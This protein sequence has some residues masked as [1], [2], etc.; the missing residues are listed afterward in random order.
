MTITR[1][2][3]P[4]S[5]H[6]GRRG[7][8]ARRRFRRGPEEGAVTAET[9]LVLPAVVLVLAAAVWVVSLA[10]AT[11]RCVDAAREAARALARGET[12]ALAR[13]LAEQV[14]PAGA[15]MRTSSD[16]G[17]VRVTVSVRARPPGPVLGRLPA[18]A[19]AGDAVTVPEGGGVD[20]DA[21]PW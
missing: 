19:V 11:L 20:A 8:T 15:E 5:V 1:T 10:A 2:T 6:R 17:L 12:P 9:A 18:V 4:A 16:G 7:T 13:Q 21:Q 3:P 14:A